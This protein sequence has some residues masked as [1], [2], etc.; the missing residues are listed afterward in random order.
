MVNDK[1]IFRMNPG[2]LLPLFF[3]FAGNGVANAS[4]E[5]HSVTEFKDAASNTVRKVVVEYLRPDSA[6]PC[7]VIYYKD[8]IAR[9][10][11][12]ANNEKGV[13][14][15]IEKKFIANMK[16]AYTDVVHEV[17]NVAPKPDFDFELVGVQENADAFDSTYRVVLRELTKLEDAEIY[18]AAQ[19][20]KFPNM[21][22]TINKLE[23]VATPYKVV[24]KRGIP[25]SLHSEVMQQ[26]KQKGFIGVRM[27]N[28]EKLKWRDR[29]VE[30]LAGDWERYLIGS[31]ISEG[32]TTEAK[33]AA[34]SGLQVDS[35][36]L[37]SC[38]YG[39]LC[40]PPEIEGL[41]DIA[42]LD[43]ATILDHELIKLDPK[44]KACVSNNSSKDQVL[45]C[46]IVSSLGKKEKRF[47]DCANSSTSK[48]DIAKCMARN[49]LSADT[50]KAIACVE[51]GVDSTGDAVTCALENVEDRNVRAV[52]RCANSNDTKKCL[53]K[54]YAGKEVTA[55]IDCAEKHG[56]NKTAMA[57][58]LAAPHLNEDQQRAVDCATSSSSVSGFA[59][60]NVMGGMD[61]TPEQRIAMECAMNSGGEPTSFATCYGIQT[62]VRELTKCFTDGIGDDGC[63]GKNNTIVKLATNYYNDI[64]KGPGKGNEIVKIRDRILG[65]DQG[66]IAMFLRDP[67]KR[68]IKVFEN[69]AKLAGKE[70]GRIAGELSP[71]KV[72]EWLKNP[73]DAWRRSD[74]GK[75]VGGAAK[76][77][78]RIAGEASPDKVKEWVEK[79]EES[80]RRSTPGKI[81]GAPGEALKKLFR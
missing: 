11:G 64:T 1:A 63:F 30:T 59:A 49:S 76:E 47:L 3:L 58:C 60:C 39:G 2:V 73:E 15:G 24:L 62:T 27:E 80:F 79:P 10:E 26:L 6:V 22:F 35:N 12:A 70:A 55:V 81:L 21:D 20:R 14:E 41:R 44:L 17:K 78:E 52:V 18:I 66:E 50:A 7:R 67:I 72:E 48:S 37:S 69:I 40:K 45:R 65:D 54:E 51:K 46:G 38:L 16:N 29:P 4:L 28:L 36:V 25:E 9:V 32:N 61:L 42:N 71:K 34:C 57:M 43:T 56:D 8:S 33:L 23:G 5:T 68:P 53:L 77:A 31:C 75:I 74:P 13:C 19:K